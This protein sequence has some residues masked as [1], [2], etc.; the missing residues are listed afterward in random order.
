M[1]EMEK[2]IRSKRDEI[3]TNPVKM[4]KIYDE[5]KILRRRKKSRKSLKRK[6]PKFN[7]F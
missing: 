7:K 5:V 4:K 2:R 1:M 3:L 6:N